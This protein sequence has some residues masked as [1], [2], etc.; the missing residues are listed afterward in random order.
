MSGKSKVVSF[1]AFVLLFIATLTPINALKEDF[2]FFSQNNVL[3]VCSCSN[4][5]NLFNLA[6]TGDVTSTYQV[7]VGGN[8]AK[9]A[10]IAPNQLIL[11]PGEKSDIFS[12]LNIPCSA[13][14]KYELI[15]EAKTKFGNTKQV[16]QDINVAACNNI[17]VSQ[18]SPAEQSACPCT[19]KTF[20]F[21]ISNNG[22]HIETFTIGIDPV[23]H[24]KVSEAVFALS[25]GQIKKLFVFVNKPCDVYGKHDF[26]LFVQAQ[27]SGVTAEVPFSLNINQCYEFDI[28]GQK[29][30]NLCNDKDNTVSF[31]IKNNAQPSNSYILGINVGGTV[32]TY[33]G[34]ALDGNK[35]STFEYNLQPKVPAGNYPMLVRGQT[36]RGDMIKDYNFTANVLSCVASSVSVIPTPGTPGP[37]AEETADSGSGDDLLKTVLMTIGAFV[38]LGVLALGFI[39]YFKSTHDKKGRKIIQPAEHVYYN[40]P[41]EAFYSQTV[42]TQSAQAKEAADVKGA[43]G[44]NTWKYLSMLILIVLFVLGLGASLLYTAEGGV[45]GTRNATT[46]YT[47]SG[48]D[49]NEITDADVCKLPYIEF[50]VGECCLD[51]NSNGVCDTDEETAELEKILEKNDTNDMLAIVFGIIAIVV[52]I[53][54]IIFLKERYDEGGLRTFYRSSKSPILEKYQKKHMDEKNLKVDISSIRWPLLIG[55]ILLV[56]LAIGGV[57]YLVNQQLVGNKALEDL[58]GLEDTDILD[59][60]AIENGEGLITVEGASVKD[61]MVKIQ[62]DE[63]SNFSVSIENPDER[64]VY[65]LAI[66]E[67]LPWLEA[68]EKIDVLPGEKGSISLIAEPD[69]TVIDGDIYII[70]AV[71]TSPV[72]QNAIKQDLFL[73][74]VSVSPLMFAVKVAG[75]IVLALVLLGMIALGGIKLTRSIKERKGIVGIVPRARKERAEAA[76][77]VE[78][79]ELISLKE[80]IFKLRKEQQALKEGKYIASQR[81]EKRSVWRMI[82]PVLVILLIIG[83]VGGLYYLDYLNIAQL[84]T[85][86]NLTVEEGLAEE[87]LLPV[88]ASAAAG[89]LIVIALAVWGIMRAVKKRKG[90]T[91]KPA[92][93]RSFFWHRLRYYTSWGKFKKPMKILGITALIL[94]LLAGIGYVAFFTNMIENTADAVENKTDIW[95]GEDDEELDELGIS[96]EDLEFGEITEDIDTENIESGKEERVYSTMD[97]IIVALLAAFVFIMCI[98]FVL[99]W[100][101]KGRKGGVEKTKPGLISFERPTLEKIKAVVPKIIPLG[102]EDKKIKKE[103]RFNINKRSVIIAAIVIAVLILAALGLLFG[104]K[105]AE[106]QIV[107]LPNISFFEEDVVVV[108][109]G[110]D[111]N[112]W[113]DKS[114]LDLRGGYIQ[115][116]DD[117]DTFV[118]VVIT[119][120]GQQ[121]TFRVG[122]L[123]GWISTVKEETA[124]EPFYEDVI[125]VVVH[126]D[127]SI[128]EGRY[129]IILTIATEA[130]DEFRQE[131][132]VEVVKGRKLWDNIWFW[133]AVG[134][135]SLAVILGIIYLFDKKKIVLRK[136]GEDKIITEKAVKPKISEA[137]REI[138]KETKPKKDMS[139][140]WNRM[141]TPSA[142]LIVLLIVCGFIFGA[143]M[144]DYLNVAEPAEPLE[145][146]VSVEE[147]NESDIE[148]AGQDIVE[149]SEETIIP[150]NIINKN[151]NE[152]FEINVNLEEVSWIRPVQEKI[153]V[154]P[155]QSNE[156]GLLITPNK[157][158]K[159]GLYKINVDIG[160]DPGKSFRKEIVVK[161]SKKD[162]WSR[163][164]PYLFYAA[165]GSVA[166]IVLV[167]VLFKQD[168]KKWARMP[169]AKVKSVEEKPAESAEAKK[170]PEKKIKKVVLGSKKPEEKLQEKDEKKTNTKI[171][172]K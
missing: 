100:K 45:I 90:T 39:V 74:I 66:N 88:Y 44:D 91:A 124:L 87:S 57:A 125:V 113:V 102:I 89:G 69:E 71:A 52:I 109:P 80:E 3:S 31:T 135:V 112:L 13:Q 98:L 165:S 38:L 127:D 9:W 99:G 20:E 129:K 10:T 14:G 104:P 85:E 34:V 119:N 160:T 111:I 103:K 130:G 118:P 33:D 110:K 136:A 143:Y 154:E 146:E 170:Y 26:T 105:I 37:V 58:G 68:D 77:N 82:I 4:T 79:A 121:N 94:L 83:V 72:L 150:L 159:N 97:Y 93:E 41:T 51:E 86:A 166:L 18:I 140:M 43:A 23:E 157:D 62:I 92:K 162:L 147:L 53:M 6:N 145:G 137:K 126:P 50:R 56:V 65:S 15:T 59:E 107:S 73:E 64:F 123:E 164:Y 144:F 76:A 11:E 153:R 131:I 12:F 35:A 8:A 156:L 95:F 101:R 42:E 17:G 30:Y 81:P 149:V 54:V 96:E 106:Q 70:E 116:M 47:I 24:I 172:L 29:E 7:Y 122:K 28:L 152:A 63:V 46:A 138:S 55:V 36:T 171:R 2:S 32:F 60:I 21:E 16:I 134:I 155:G 120:N 49:V 75:A 169:K 115:A 167:L 139:A 25:P 158:V 168:P 142:V 117:E 114:N 128:N 5:K 84:E 151:N 27:N 1:L 78:S 163:V 108:E 40:Q 61:D 48:A 148:I 67:D 19:P 22:N 132:P 133:P 141:K 161:I